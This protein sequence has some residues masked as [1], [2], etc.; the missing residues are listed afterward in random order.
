MPTSTL[1]SKGQ[2]TIPRAIREHLQLRPGDRIDF[3]IGASGQVIVRP[4]TRSI[5]ELE[6]SLKR[7]GQKRLDVE[8]MDAA[9]RKRFSRR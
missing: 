4:L 6:A 1:T 2:T 3:V 7:P 9:I 8:E 5:L